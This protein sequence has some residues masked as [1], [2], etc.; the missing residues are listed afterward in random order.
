MDFED[1]KNRERIG[2][3]RRL[4]EEDFERG[5]S[6][7]YKSPVL[8]MNERAC[9]NRRGLPPSDLLHDIISVHVGTSIHGS[10]RTYGERISPSPKSRQSDFSDPML[11]GVEEVTPRYHHASSAPTLLDLGKSSSA[12]GS[13]F[14][15]TNTKIPMGHHKVPPPL[16]PAK[17]RYDHTTFS[18]PRNTAVNYQHT[19]GFNGVTAGGAEFAP[20]ANCKP[21][22]DREA[23]PGDGLR[24]LIFTPSPHPKRSSTPGGTVET[25]SESKTPA[26]A[27]KSAF[28]AE[29]ETVDGTNDACWKR[30]VD[31]SG[32]SV[33]YQNIDTPPLSKATA[34][35][36]AALHNEAAFENFQTLAGPKDENP[37]LHNLRPRSNTEPPEHK[38][39]QGPELNENWIMVVPN[40]EHGGGNH[41]IDSFQD[42]DSV[43][44]E[45]L[46]G[47]E[48][49]DDNNTNEQ[50]GDQNDASMVENQPS[51]SSVLAQ[52]SSDGAQEASGAIL[53]SEDS[54]SSNSYL[55]PALP[56][57]AETSSPDPLN[58]SVNSSNFVN[59]KKTRHLPATK[60]FFTKPTPF[61]GKRVR[62]DASTFRIDQRLQSK[63]RL[64]DEED[65]DSRKKRGV[66][67]RHTII[68]R[69]SG[70]T[71]RLPGSDEDEDIVD[72]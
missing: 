18:S 72:D 53:S 50:D 35:D 23:R 58:R 65:K 30:F 62:G 9:F 63:E 70:M 46:F 3:R 39:A 1:A 15:D 41:H 28:S 8:S 13:S 59:P 12:D 25:A 44:R 45:F 17:E 11:L 34:Q 47:N 49:P 36:L 68:Q 20:Q 42:D 61:I 67:R 33:T 43:W 64:K 7:I 52:A 48:E 38:D 2:K 69:Q 19:D 21:Y 10:Q 22:S 29:S 71:W 57:M 26:Q 24:R 60:P 6:R 66:R 27:S 51:A 31:I 40:A 14:F 4:R 37:K 5:N 54:P 32:S 55:V 56:R 16:S